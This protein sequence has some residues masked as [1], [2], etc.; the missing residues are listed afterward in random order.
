MTRTEVQYTGKNI[1]DLAWQIIESWCMDTL[2]NY[3]V[4]KLIEEFTRNKCE[5]IEAWEDYNGG[6]E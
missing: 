2:I 4:E 1:D 5:F 3:A 6:E